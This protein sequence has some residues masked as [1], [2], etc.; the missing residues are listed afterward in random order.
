MHTQPRPDFRTSTLFTSGV[1]TYRCLS[2]THLRSRQHTPPLTSPTPSPSV[3]ILISDR[4]SPYS[5]PFLQLRS[6]LTTPPPSRHPLRY[7]RP[8]RYPPS[9][10]T[11]LPYLP[12]SHSSATLPPSYDHPPLFR[13]S[14]SDTSI[15]LVT[16]YYVNTIANIPR[17]SNPASVTSVSSATPELRGPPPALSPFPVSHHP[18]FPS[19]SCPS[20]PRPLYLLSDV[21]QVLPYDLRYR[22]APSNPLFP[23]GRL[24]SDSRE[25][26]QAASGWVGNGPECTAVT[27][28]RSSGGDVDV[29]GMEGWK[30]VEGG[31]SPRI[32]GID[33]RQQRE[34]ER[35]GGGY[36]SR[37]GLGWREVEDLGY[38]SAS[39]KR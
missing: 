5:P 30:R 7:L 27:E 4:T 31:G 19:S 35:A 21:S 3:P 2:D 1:I 10:L 28:L 20:G 33:Q 32:V 6:P 9:D 16:S 12:L 14:H 38:D 11:T 8:F 15:A 17:T 29:D 13:T 24:R 26:A 39:I 34:I 25:W 18:H 36:K 23:F 37:L 22:S